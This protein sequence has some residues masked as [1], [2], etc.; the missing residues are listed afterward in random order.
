VTLTT[1]LRIATIISEEFEYFGYN[2]A[3]NASYVLANGATLNTNGATSSYNFNH[4]NITVNQNE[5]QVT[6]RSNG[7]Y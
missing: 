3:G 5:L 4:T 6:P 1:L 2:T 7:N